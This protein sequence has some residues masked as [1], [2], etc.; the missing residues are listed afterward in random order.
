M[1]GYQFTHRAA[2]E[3]AKLPKDIQKQVFADIEAVCENNHP[4]QSRNVL[5]LKGGYDADT[6]RLRS[7]NY[8]IIFRFISGMILIDSVRN[9]QKGYD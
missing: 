3:V 4:L 8:R 5:K 6:F 2:K 1:F 7:G 9:R